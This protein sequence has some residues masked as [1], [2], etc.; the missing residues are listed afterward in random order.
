MNIA[1]SKYNEYKEMR[2]KGEK[3]KEENQLSIFDFMDKRSYKE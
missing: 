2:R 1:G 3:E